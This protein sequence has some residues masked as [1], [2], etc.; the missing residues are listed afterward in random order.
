MA[1]Q[2]VPRNGP[3]TA[4]ANPKQ[5]PAAVVPN[6]YIRVMALR[7][8]FCPSLES[9]GRHY[10]RE[11]GDTFT[12]ERKRFTSEWMQEAEEGKGLPPLPVEPPPTTLPTRP[13]P[14]TIA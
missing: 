6:D 11:P 13:K 2:D 4:A 14:V 12:V 5:V 8:G 7:N 3:Q 10:Y 9:G 1:I